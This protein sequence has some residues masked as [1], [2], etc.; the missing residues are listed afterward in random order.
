MQSPQYK[1]THTSAARRCVFRQKERTKSERHG[2]YG[3]PNP[4]CLPG[5]SL[6]CLATS[7][8]TQYHQMAIVR[9]DLGWSGDQPTTPLE[10][11]LQR[12]PIFEDTLKRELQRTHQNSGICR[13]HF[14]LSSCRLAF[15]RERAF[16]T[17]HFKASAVY[18]CYLALRLNRSG[19][20]ASRSRSADEMSGVA[21]NLPAVQH[22]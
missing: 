1:R 9:P 6:G 13:R 21:A 5:G 3:W 7:R 22:V 18:A 11:T 10:S 20:N 8:P 4:T 14:P 2:G 12:V 17:G 19:S 16:S 15:R